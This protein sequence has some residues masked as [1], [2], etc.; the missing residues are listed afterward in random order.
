[1]KYLFYDITD[2]FFNWHRWHFSDYTKTYEPKI[3]TY[4]LWFKCFRIRGKNND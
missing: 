3:E 2:L 1:M 4:K